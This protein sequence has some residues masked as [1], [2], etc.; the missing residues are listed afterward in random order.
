[1]STRLL[2]FAILL[3]LL[4]AAAA[5][6]EPPTDEPVVWFDEESSIEDGLKRVHASVEKDDAK[7]AAIWL[8]KLLNEHAA[9]VMEADDGA[10]LP[11]WR[12]LSRRVAALPKSF[13]EA[14]VTLYGGEGRTRVASALGARDLAALQAAAQSS[15]PA[16]DDESLLAA[17]RALAE[18]GRLGAA[19]ALLEE[20][21]LRSPPSALPAALLASLYAGRGDRRS[22]ENLRAA[23]PADRLGLP[24]S[25]GA[26]ACTLGE[27]VDRAL[28]SLRARGPI[29]PAAGREPVDTPSWSL[30]V[31][32]LGESF[33]GLLLTVNNWAGGTRL[34]ASM[35]AARTLFPLTSAITRDLVLVHLGKSLFAYRLADGT[36]AW[37]R[38]GE[39]NLAEFLQARCEPSTT[40]HYSIV[41]DAE[42]AYATF[43]GRP[44]EG[45]G[46][47]DLVCVS[48]A[49]GKT[50]W[51]L[52]A[53]NLGKD[54]SFIGIPHVD[55]DRLYVSVIGTE[56][57]EQVFVL[58]L[59]AA[60]GK[61]I[62]TCKLSSHTPPPE[63]VWYFYPEPVPLVT[64][65]R[66]VVYACTG[67]GGFAA[68]D[69]AT[70]EFLWGLKYP[71]QVMDSNSWIDLTQEVCWL[72]PPNSML[73][74]DDGVW[75]AP[76]DA[77]RIYLVDTT[78][79]TIT[80]DHRK[81]SM[82]RYRFLVG[83]TPRGLVLGGPEVGLY[84]PREGLLRHWTLA[85][86]DGGDR[87]ALDGGCL[88]VPR[89]KEIVAIDTETFT[90]VWRRPIEKGTSGDVLISDRGVA[91]VS[92]R[93][94]TFFPWK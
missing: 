35:P 29:A 48:L 60:T 84:S 91:I 64:L 49:D 45:K 62:W 61:V 81:D 72:L 36:L 75:M 93:R 55:R 8:Q 63:D 6:E 74:A 19:E 40:R 38:G 56:M 57:R 78:T 51:K 69:P 2:P 53:G 24:V 58:C 3:G 18:G 21:V 10:F 83:T 4:V 26:Q 46:R 5:E 16:L 34:D 82:E 80:V 73:P 54:Y 66:G 41:A 1:M 25:V 39:R 87:P 12:V 28:D 23:L 71:C 77:P 37:T 31:P 68:L 32:V 15:F 9:K 90:P 70:G 59:E 88:V 52:D 11:A 27:T 86:R 94:V 13:V 76:H 22:L 17:A 47:N 42:R 14:Y 20:R 89:A 85:R 7:G 67:T 50:V 79:R 44:L 43:E 92:P 30:P 33:D 65:H